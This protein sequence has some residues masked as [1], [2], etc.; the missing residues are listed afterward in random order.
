[1]SLNG[2]QVPSSQSPESSQWLPSDPSVQMYCPQKPDM[3]SVPSV[4]VEPSEPSEQKPRW[5]SRLPLHSGVSS[6]RE[7][8]LPST[9][10]RYAHLFDA[11]FSLTSHGAPMPSCTHAPS[12]HRPRGQCTSSM[13]GAPGPPPVQRPSRQYRVTQCASSSHGRLKGAAPHTPASA[14]GGSA[15]V[16]FLQWRSRSQGSPT[17]PAWQAPRAHMRPSA[18][19]AV[20]KYLSPALPS[21]HCSSMQKGVLQ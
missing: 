1:M 9:H 3:Q 12:S 11:Q 6:Q 18:Q 21:E 4:H 17:S 15:H 2:S 14:P 16:R 19:F 8:R 5:H 13:H 20:S 10:S 7:P